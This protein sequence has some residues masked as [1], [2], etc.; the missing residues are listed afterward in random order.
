MENAN[1]VWSDEEF[2]AIAETILDSPWI[3]PFTIVAQFIVSLKDIYRFGTQPRSGAVSLL[4]RVYD[5]I[6]TDLGP[7]HVLVEYTL[8]PGYRNSHQWNLIA[9]GVH[10]TLP[11]LV[12]L[13]NA[14][15]KMEEFENGVRYDSWLPKGGES[16][17]T[18]IRQ[19]I[20]WH[21]TMRP[22]I[23]ELREA[24]N[25]L[26]EQN[27]EME[28]EIVARKQAETERERLILELQEALSRIKVLDGL[29]PTC[30]FCK[31]IRN[32]KGEWEQIETYIRDRSEADFSHSICPECMEKRYP[33]TF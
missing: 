6:F 15:I 29:L 30:S 24:Y 10:K 21:F 26:Q 8:R 20:V 31:K 19:L 4:F 27:L 9:L 25:A 7:N 1:K 14:T 11:R 2:T 32:D 33:E 17:L 23:D 18:R 13:S 16:I 22:A 28:K 3:R 12:G 5:G